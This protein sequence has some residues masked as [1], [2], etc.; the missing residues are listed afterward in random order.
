M[1]ISGIIR[2]FSDS[3]KY[4]ATLKFQAILLFVVTIALI[5]RVWGAN[6]QG[7]F[8][9][10]AVVL[11]LF[12]TNTYIN[13]TT[14]EL[15]DFNKATLV[16]L[17]TLQSKINE[18]V[19]DKIRL[20]GNMQLPDKDVIFLSEKNKLDS[21]Y[22]D[23][24]MI[25]F[26]FSIL[27]LYEYNKDEFYMLLKGTNNILKIRKQIEEYYTANLLKTPDPVKQRFPSFKET[28]S[29]T[30]EPLYLE[31]IHEM[32]E[33]AIGLKV[34]CI[35]N[36]QNIIYGVPKVS[37][38]YTYIDDIIERYSILISRNLAIINEYHINA[39]KETGI[40]TRTKFVN[41]TG[42]KSYD[43]MSNQNIIP[44]KNLGV[45]AEVHQLYV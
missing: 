42:T 4:Q 24:T 6:T 16:K 35:N 44:T 38:M 3:S 1:D 29:P 26:L 25:Y 13:I 23:S 9:I 39:I 41:Y 21:L 33:I 30:Q 2:L 18:Y 37:K 5:S 31:N 19:S 45:R 36:I 17:Q 11:A 8:V 20:A 32:F 22:I 7:I 40:N 28:T 12:L 43:R 14:D 34:N 10:V 15:G 27:P